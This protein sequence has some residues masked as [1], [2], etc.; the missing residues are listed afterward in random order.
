MRKLIDPQKFIELFY[1][2]K[3]SAKQIAKYFGCAVGTIYAHRRDKNLPARG[4]VVHGMLGKK[5][6]PEIRAKISNAIKGKQA[7]EKNPNWKGGKYV[8][9][10]GIVFIR[11]KDDHPYACGG[12][13]REHRYVMEKHLG[14]HLKP[15]EYIHHI[16]FNNSDNRIEN[17][18]LTNM[19]EHAFLH[20]P[21]GSKF[22]KNS[23]L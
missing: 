16:N 11:V 13:I 4:Y 10:T 23:N 15:D 1:E 21:K 20:F 7:M 5:H 9:K 3:W 12:Y 18:K 17:L 19:Y 8:S 14:R 22:G 6:S 2:K